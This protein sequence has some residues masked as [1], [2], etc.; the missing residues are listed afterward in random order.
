[1]DKEKYMEI[2]EKFWKMNTAI[3]N[4]CGFPE[5]IRPP[6]KGRA[7]KGMCIGLLKYHERIRKKLLIE[8]AKDFPQDENNP[9]TKDGWHLF[10]K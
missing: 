3:V 5:I 2:G 7:F 4:F 6:I 1:M 10:Q 8:Y 9:F